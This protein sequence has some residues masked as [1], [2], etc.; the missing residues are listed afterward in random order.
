VAN[1]S[2]NEVHRRERKRLIELENLKMAQK[3]YKI[4][5]S[6]PARKSL[7]QEYRHH[8]KTKV[9]RCRLPIVN[10]K[11][12]LWNENSIADGSTAIAIENGIHRNGSDL[13]RGYIESK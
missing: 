4:K 11:K 1:I 10:M 2:L 7:E 5:S 12:N 8:L 3:L 9:L 6:L 13:T